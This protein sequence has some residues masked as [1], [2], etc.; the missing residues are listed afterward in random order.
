MVG[1]APRETQHFTRRVRAVLVVDMV[2]S[3]RLIQQD[4]EGVIRRWRDFVDAVVHAELP[5]HGGRMVKSLGDGML[6]ELDSAPSAVKC[7]LAMQARI[8]ASEASAQPDRQIQLRMGIHVADVIVDDIDLFGEGVNLSAR[9]AG[10]AGPSEIVVSAEVRDG[11]TA[12]LDADIED[13][14]EC[15]L[16]HV[17]Q[18]VRAYRVGPPG[19]WPVI[20]RGSFTMPGLQPMI[21]VIPFTA[22]SAEPEYE[23]VGE[24]LADEVISALSRTTHLNVISR[25]STT[26]FRGRGA[27]L[28]EIGACLKADYVLSGTYRVAGDQLV[29]VAELADPKS[30]R[31][32]WGDSLKGRV[33]GVVSGEDELTHRIV[34]KVSAAVMAREVERARSQALPTLEGYTLL[35]GAIALMHRASATDF[36]RARQLLETLAE[37]VRRSAAPHAW[38]AKWHVLRFTR[39]WIHEQSG[40]ATYALECTRRALDCDPECSLALTI[41]GFV[42][43]NLLKRLDIG[44]ERYETALLVNPNDSLAWL[45][46]GTLHAFRG[47][48]QMAVEHTDFA[49]ALSPFD[50]I[51]YFYESLA[52]TA[53]LSAGQYQRAVE[54]AQH[55]IRSNRVHTSTLRAL[56]ISQSLLGRLE[57]AQQTVREL[58]RRDPSLSVR[59]YLARSPSGE[60]DT[61]RLWSEALHRAGLP[62]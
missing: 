51:R 6:I 30:G 16:K 59:T 43:T 42:H 22:R 26:V 28:E 56:A 47:E 18:P 44:L 20:E 60:Y 40:E 54:L 45:L 33:S 53:A 34:G 24:M 3:V 36:D 41:D 50:P 39:G 17:Q 12:L 2:E 14:G 58:L 15:Y 61:G 37:R 29:V 49:L 55:S 35:L 23:V 5:T 25:L 31:V 57:E 8:S 32:I 19:H 9:L 21:A 4:E 7:A 46:K 48:G 10:L 11:L 13:L 27:S 52:S 1:G 38:L 62:E